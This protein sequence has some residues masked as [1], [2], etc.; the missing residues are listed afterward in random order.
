MELQLM[1]Y[2]RL[3]REVERTRV[4]QTELE[5]DRERIRGDMELFRHIVNKQT[6]RRTDRAIPYV[7]IAT[8]KIKRAKET[9]TEI[10]RAR[11]S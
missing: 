3:T 6:D 5:G 7:A 9:Q 4:S 2:H 8:K 11:E 10:E 1:A